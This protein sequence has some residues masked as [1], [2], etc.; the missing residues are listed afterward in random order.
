MRALDR[1]LLRDL[2]G[3][4]GQALAIGFVLVAGVTSFVAMTSVM[5]T[6][7]H[8]LDVYYAEYRFPDGFARVVR[9]PERVADALR[10]VDGV[11]EVET[12]ITAGAN[13]E[14]PGFPD[15]IAAA[16]HSLPEGRQPALNRLYIR[17]GQLPAPGREGEALVSEQLAE[18]HGLRPGDALTAIISGRRRALTVVGVVLTPEHLWQV[19]PGSLFPDPER[20]GVLWMGRPALA[21]AYD[22]EGAFNDVAF[23][24][25]P[26]ATIEDVTQRVDLVLDRYGG[27]GAHGRADHPS[28]L[29]IS[30]EFDQLRGMSAFLPVVF[31][32]VAAF[33]LNIVVMRMITLQREQIAVLKAFGYRDRD[34]GMH[35]VKLVLVVAVAGAAVGAVLGVWGGRALADLYLQYFRFPHLEHA[36]SPRVLVLATA[37]T[38]GAS[39]LGVVQAVRRAVR[40]PPAEAMRPAPPARFRPTLV[41]RLGLQGALS[42][43]SR[44][45]LRNV[46]RQPL[47]AAFTVLGIAISA[48]LLIMGL[49]FTDAFDRVIEVQ[50]GIAQREDLTVG[51]GDARPAAAA[52]ELRALPGVLHA[53]PFRAV[54][55]R[56][57]AG[58]R[59]YQTAIE[60][61]PAGAYLRRVIDARLQPVPI[62][63]AG[64]ILS[65]GLADLLAVRPGDLLTVEVLEGRRLTRTVPV[66]GV[67][68]QYIGIGAYMDLD[69][70]NRLA[71]SGHA[72]SGAFLLVDTAHEGALTEALRQRPHVASIV[73]TESAIRS[74]R[75]EST[76]TLLVFALVLSLFAGAIAFGVVYN[77]IRIALSERDREL[78]S[79]RVLGFTR[80]EIAYVLLGESALL[81]LLALPLGFVLGA[82]G[83]HLTISMVDTE[84]MTIPVVLTRRTFAL[85][86]A[87]VLGA[88]LLSAALVRRRLDRLDL[89][90]VL[91]TRE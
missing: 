50:Y 9:A 55:V 13:L 27:L 30:M 83:S 22:M 1:K 33:L 43:P 20:Y 61:V 57:R 2:W 67:T 14:V 29:L 75:E 74:Y 24:L 32:A 23:T 81:V 53:E 44:I 56:L 25:A 73:R 10:E 82:L 40:L 17:D 8:T 85:A 70:A 48:A 76:E 36:L 26:G 39:L 69:A 65:E 41:E 89:I 88:A 90:G 6:L 37:L 52:H 19:E 34:V 5:E 16:I 42:Q 80:G 15:P 49:F 79:L 64:V 47:K 21:A 51:F 35:Y 84:L 71:G 7:E 3:M 12:R 62:P 31:L 58:H 59:T 77:S 86:A 72:I 68:P 46:E 18:A 54:P 38:T 66:A 87:V 63:P 91:K 28:H 45:I 60:G 78:A 4:R 11:A